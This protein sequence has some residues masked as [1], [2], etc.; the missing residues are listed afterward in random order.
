MGWAYRATPRWDTRKLNGFRPG[1]CAYDQ[2]STQ[3]H[4]SRRTYPLLQK[5]VMATTR[6][7]PLSVAAFG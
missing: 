4:T 6:M 2:H 3:I 1:H 7:P 5:H